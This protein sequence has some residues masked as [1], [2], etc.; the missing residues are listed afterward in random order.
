MISIVRTKNDLEHL[1]N[2]TFT[3]YTAIDSETMG[4]T[5]YELVCQMKDEPNQEKKKE[6]SKTLKD[7][8]NLASD[9]YNNILATVQLC[10][11]NMDTLVIVL[12]DDCVR[13][14]TKEFL[15][16]ALTK[17]V[18]W[19]GHNIK[20]D[21]HQF[22]SHLGLSFSNQLIHDTMVVEALLNGTRDSKSFKLSEVQKEYDIPSEFTK[23]VIDTPFVNWW[24]KDIPQ[25]QLDYMA[26]DVRVLMYIQNQQ[27]KRL[28]DQAGFRV[29]KLECSI[30]PGLVMLESVNVQFDIGKLNK[31][32]RKA[33][34]LLAVKREAFSIAFPGVNP[35]S[36]VQMLPAI[37]EMYGV[38]PVKEEYD[39]Q[40]RTMVH[41]PSTDKNAL[42]QAGIADEPLIQNYIAIKEISKWLTTAKKWYLAKSMLVNYFQTPVRGEG[43]TDGGTK[44]GRFSTSPQIQN[45]EEFMKQFIT[46]HDNDGNRSIISS[47]DYVGIELR[48]FADRANERTLRQMFLDG[49][50]PHK[51]MCAKAFNIPLDEVF[52]GS[53]IYR[54]AKAI[55]F[56][57]IYGMYPARFSRQVTIASGGHIK[58]SIDEAREFRKAFFELYED[59][60]PYHATVFAQGCLNGYVSTA[61]G[62][63]LYYNQSERPELEQQYVPFYDPSSHMWVGPYYGQNTIQFKGQV[64]KTV[65]CVVVNPDACYRAADWRWRN[66]CYNAPIQGTGADGAKEAFR[67]I[68]NTID[69]NTTKLFAMV[70][71]SNDAY[72]T[73]AD[74]V[75]DAVAQ[76]DQCM[77]DGMD[78]YLPSIPVEVEHTTGLCWAK[79]PRD[80]RNDH[81]GLWIYPD[82]YND[83]D[84]EQWKNQE[85]QTPYLI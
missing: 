20:F 58:V 6:I 71:D 8:E 64:I 40:L 13:Q 35:Q 3:K 56:G 77:K 2:F 75:A 85:F 54:V 57:F 63:R 21:L 39:K 69:W 34:D 76:I 16:N 5:W 42:L 55:N 60:E 46:F 50:S 7:Y 26:N 10:N 62:R 83:E 73:S 1:S 43:N 78:K 45:I 70:H 11:Q 47:S 51:E 25:E 52:K 33:E 48:L 17:D 4:K 41:R 59:A 84:L 18:V 53:D 22:D 15:A 67:L 81:Y 61:S 72:H 24:A 31:F 49:R 36:S 80:I 19:I 32:I 28:T 44:T 68:A 14:A 23:V 37:E 79:P 12:E 30:I 29:R 38:T 82:K 65:D 66:K 9:K 74:V 27:H